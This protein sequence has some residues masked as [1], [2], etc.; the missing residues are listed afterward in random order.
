MELQQAP[1]AVMY[2]KRDYSGIS[3]ILSISKNR[4]VLIENP[5]QKCRGFFLNCG[6]TWSCLSR[7]IEILIIMCLLQLFI[8]RNMTYNNP[9]MDAR[10]FNKPFVGFHSATNYAS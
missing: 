3:F 5:R 10:I 2:Q 9:G 8:F 6:K 4:I 7:K 1:S